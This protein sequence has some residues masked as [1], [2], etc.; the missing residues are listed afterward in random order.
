[1]AMFP[2][3]PSPPTHTEREEHGFISTFPENYGGKKLVLLKMLCHQGEYVT[4]YSMMLAGST[5]KKSSCL[6]AIA[7]IKL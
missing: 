2:C 3:A 6:I 7:E 4:N 1:M 5:E